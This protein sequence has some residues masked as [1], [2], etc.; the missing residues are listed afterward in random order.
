ML[1]ALGDLEFPKYIVASLG[2]DDE[3]LVVSAL[4][5]FEQVECALHVDGDSLSSAYKKK[6][7]A[8]L[9]ARF[10]PHHSSRGGDADVAVSAQ[11]RL[12]RADA[13]RRRARPAGGR[14]RVW[15]STISCFHSK[16]LCNFKLLIKTWSRLRPPT[17]RLVAVR[18]ARCT[19]SARPSLTWRRARKS[20]SRWFASWS[21]TRS[22]HPPP[23]WLQEWF[24]CKLR[25]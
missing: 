14:T 4:K 1:L 25:Q 11:P 7:D 5:F 19:S 24:C 9:L 22:C 17:R 13:L 18:C 20:C 21:P 15:T 2:S 16:N 23:R 3:P 10:R 6:R 12:Q 8:E